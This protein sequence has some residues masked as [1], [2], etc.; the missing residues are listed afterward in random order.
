MHINHN[1][2]VVAKDEII[3][4]APIEKVVGNTNRY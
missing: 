2:P 4:Y 1:A 3:I